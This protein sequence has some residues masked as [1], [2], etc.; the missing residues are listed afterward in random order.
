LAVFLYGSALDRLF[1]PDSDLDVA[2]L[3][4]KQHPLSWPDQARLM[5]A[6]ERTTGRGVD[7]RM[8]RE[9]SLRPPR[10]NGCVTL[11]ADVNPD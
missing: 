5:D 4:D 11:M 10:K 6:L 9:S 1:R 3:D 2:V 7:L 8:L